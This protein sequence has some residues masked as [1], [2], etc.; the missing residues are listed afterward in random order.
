MAKKKHKR[1]GR[2]PAALARYWAG[3]RGKKRSRHVAKKRKGRKGRKHHTRARSR[4]RGGGGGG[5]SSGL[6]IP[7]LVASAA[8]GALEA[9]AIKDATSFLNKIPR[10]IDQLGYAGGT[11]LALYA[12]SMVVKHPYLRAA[13]KATSQI[14]AYQMGRAGGAL[15]AATAPLTISGISPGGNERVLRDEQIGEIEAEH[16][17]ALSEFGDTPGH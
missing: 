14:A 1:K 17:G 4:R 13:V 10:P 9:S 16:I 12:L 3:K 8:Y 6:D 2:M 7:V 15:K 5:G 11:A